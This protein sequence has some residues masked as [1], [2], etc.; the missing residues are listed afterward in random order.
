MEQVTF[1]I[2]NFRVIVIGSGQDLYDSVDSKNQVIHVS[3]F[4]GEGFA[5]YGWNEQVQAMQYD[6][7]PEEYLTHI[8]N[9]VGSDQDLIRGLMQC[10]NDQDEDGLYDYMENNEGQ[11]AWFDLLERPMDEETLTTC[12]SNI[13]VLFSKG[14]IEAE[15][16]SEKGLTING[17]LIHFTDLAGRF[18]EE[19]E[20]VVVYE[21]HLH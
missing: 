16:W 1:I 7:T 20:V 11:L 4:D 14:E 12:A 8:A 10:A 17:E 15:K 18:D 6:E 19:V 3:N 9:H 13:G 2:K 21:K 5:Y